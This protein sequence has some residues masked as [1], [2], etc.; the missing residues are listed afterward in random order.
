MV[1]ADSD[2]S[3]SSAQDVHTLKTKKLQPQKLACVKYCRVRGMLDTNHLQLTLSSVMNQIR[4]RNISYKIP[5]QVGIP[6]R[7]GV[8]PVSSCHMSIR[9]YPNY[10]HIHGHALFDSLCVNVSPT[11]LRPLRVVRVHNRRSG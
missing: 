11:C 9:M 4:S 6:C 3:S 10:A 5:R 1:G 8:H 7:Q 2:L